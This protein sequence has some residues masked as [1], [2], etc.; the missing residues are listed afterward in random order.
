MTPR[1]WIHIAVTALSIALLLSLPRVF[2]SESPEITRE[3]TLILGTLSSNPK[4]AF[5]RAQ[6]FA[7]YLAANLHQHGIVQAKV[8]VAKTNLQL[9][10]WVKSGQVDIVSETVY[11]SDDLIKFSHAE[12]I[13]LRWKNGVANYAS[14]FFVHQN[15]D[16][17]TLDDLVGKVIVFEDRNSTS[18]FLI[19]ISVLIEQGYPLHEV[20]S[21]RD[22]PPADKIGYFFSDEFSSAG[23]E[24]NM[25]SWVHRKIVSAAAFSDIDW[26]RE[27]PAPIKEQLRVIYTSPSVPRAFMLVRPDM[28][29]DLKQAISQVLFL[30][31]Q[32]PSAALPLKK[33]KE[34]AKFDPITDDIEQSIVWSLQQKALVDQYLGR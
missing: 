13:A 23:G 11:A 6:P 32:D 12:M 18:A 34:T 24:S 2:A 30:A 10:N 17:H 5:K 31:D 4:K 8:V 14:L 21:P 19:P 3:Q 22:L 15:S 27:I 33:Y 29:P 16:I 7:D 20:T 25:M 9:A 1:H 26:E 28:D